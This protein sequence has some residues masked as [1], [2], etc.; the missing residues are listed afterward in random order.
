MMVL[1]YKISF[2]TYTSYV[3]NGKMVSIRWFKCAC[4]LTE[5]N[6]RSVRCRFPPVLPLL[7]FRAVWVLVFRLGMLR[8][9]CAFLGKVPEIVLMRQ[10]ITL[11]RYKKGRRR[12]VSPSPA[13]VSPTM[14]AFKSATPNFSRLWHM[15]LQSLRAILEMS[16]QLCS[17][18]RQACEHVIEQEAQSRAA[19][20]LGAA[21]TCVQAYI[22]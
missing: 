10:S 4:T 16:A 13:S 1:K 15:L 2:V 7:D 6:T 21:C 9:C 20:G 17:R 3:E 12:W 8:L 18:D 11:K 19:L 22:I 14:S 5:F